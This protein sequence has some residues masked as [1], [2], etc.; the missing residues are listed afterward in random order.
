M[1]AFEVV[2]KLQIKM[3]NFNKTHHKI[4]V[5]TPTIISIKRVKIQV[6]NIVDKINSQ[7]K[8]H[9]IFDDKKK[10]RRILCIYKLS[11]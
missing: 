1:G 8:I 3:E 6:S 2:Y 7:T 9:W 4:I 10:R 5:K 11:L